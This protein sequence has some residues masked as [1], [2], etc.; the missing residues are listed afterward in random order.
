VHRSPIR[1]VKMS[2]VMS[3]KR[4]IEIKSKQ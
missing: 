3:Y 4:Y 2:V 1:N